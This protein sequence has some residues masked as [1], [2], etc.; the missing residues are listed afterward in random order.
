V[1][2]EVSNPAQEQD[3]EQDQGVVRDR[4]EYSNKISGTAQFSGAVQ[5]CNAALYRKNDIELSLVML[6]RFFQKMAFIKL[7]QQMG[8]VA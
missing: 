6:G 8:L 4:H 5:G 3:A 1:E 7:K 2:L